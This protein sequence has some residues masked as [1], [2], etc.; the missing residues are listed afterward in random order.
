MSPGEGERDGRG[1]AEVSNG[2]LSEGDAQKRVDLVGSLTHECRR[3]RGYGRSGT[4]EERGGLNV[5]NRADEGE[6][7]EGEHSQR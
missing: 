4:S 6:E 1:E 5:L 3:A 7:R 2:R